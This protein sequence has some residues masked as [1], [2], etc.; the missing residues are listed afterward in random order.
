MTFDEQRSQPQPCPCGR[1]NLTAAGGAGVVLYCPWAV[2]RPAASLY[3]AVVAQ[4][5]SEV[6]E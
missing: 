3:A 2:V 4:P 1:H 6:C 5:D